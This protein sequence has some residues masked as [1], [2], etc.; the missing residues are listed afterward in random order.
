[1][2]NVNSLNVGNVVIY[3]GKYC[4]LV[5]KEHVK[6][7]KGGA[8]LQV[9]MKDIKNGNKIPARFNTS[10][11]VDV[12]EMIEKSYQYQYLDGD[13]LSLMNMETYEQFLL[14]KNL[15]SELSFPFLQEGMD[16]KV[17]YCDGEP[18]SVRIPEKITMLVKSAE[19]S[20]KGQTQTATFKPA[21]LENDVR[22]M[23]PT[24]INGGD[25]IV[26]RTEDATYVERAK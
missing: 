10:E 22:V 21:I 13:S 25:K 26:I 5:K 19:I 14:D 8:F 17:S 12:A 18:I 16:V 9:E 24:F 6:P 1:M 11:D 3:N 2:V 7:G 4:L 20:I 23:V 15:V